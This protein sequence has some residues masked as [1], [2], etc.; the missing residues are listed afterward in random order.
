MSLINKMLNDLERRVGDSQTNNGVFAG[1]HSVRVANAKNT[2]QWLLIAL[3]IGLAAGVF[4]AKLPVSEKNAPGNEL[5]PVSE[6]GVEP[7]VDLGPAGA[8]AA[9]AK[10][11][12]ANDPDKPRETPIAKDVEQPR[13][14]EYTEPTKAASAIPKPDSRATA[15][16]EV[17]EKTI[18]P[19]SATERAENAYRSGLRAFETGDAADAE[20]LLRGALRLDPDHLPARETLAGL[21]VAQSRWQPAREVLETGVKSYPEH[22]RFIQWLAQIYVRLEEEDKAIAF[23]E[24]AYTKG[25][26]DPELLAFLGALYNRD[27]QHHKAAQAY[28]AAVQQNPLQGKWWMGMGLAL[29]AAGEPKAAREA[30]QKA[31][32]TRLDQNLVAYVRERREAL[33]GS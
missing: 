9:E 30:Y 31:L 3:L 6:S 13:A 12:K 29:E 20:R 2:P 33:E 15:K 22:R 19:L 27:G 17:M 10:P 23:L 1:L 4:I 8:E 5:A 28:A 26:T 7:L 18:H 14:P 21:L 25:L 32:E 11:A 24:Q 16:P